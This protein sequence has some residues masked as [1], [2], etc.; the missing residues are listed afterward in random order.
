MQTL[1]ARYKDMTRIQDGGEIPALHGIRTLMV[2]IVAAFHIWQQSWLTPT[3][4]IFGQVISLDVLLRSGY[5][6]VDGLLLLSGFL[7][8]LPYAVAAEGGKPLPSILPFYRKRFWRI[9]PSYAFNMMVML[10]VVALPQ[11]LYKQP[12]DMALDVLAHMSFTHNWFRFSYYATPLNGALWTLAV[13]M[14]FY[15]IFPLLARSFARM[16]AL[17]YSLMTG[18]AFLFR[19]WVARWPD[20]SMGFNQLPAFLDVYA[21]GFVAAGIYVSLRRRVKEDGWVNVLMTACAVA[22]LMV[23]AQLARGQAGEASGE[24]IRLGQMS[25]R[26]LQSVMTALCVLGLSLGLGGVRLLFGNPI[27]RFLSGISYQVYLWHQVL[28]VQLLRWNIP[29]SAIPNP[30]RAGDL[31]WQRQYVLLCWLGALG[32]AAATT[33]FIERPLARLG[34]GANMK[35]IKEKRRK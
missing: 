28:A 20:T 31:S 16:P 7:C 17:T 8:Y 29:Y 30:N 22:A 11:G 1:I 4:R 9:V 14:Q 26:Y 19:F 23:L 33:Y 13:E 18:F 5:M 35:T 3:L 25:R 27:S 6:W 15:L 2:L 32:L 34:S 12:G 24:G 10:L 21:N